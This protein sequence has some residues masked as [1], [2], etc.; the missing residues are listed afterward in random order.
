MTLTFP[1]GSHNYEFYGDRWS[2]NANLL[3]QSTI[4]LLYKCV[5]FYTKWVLPPSSGKQT[6]ENYVIECFNPFLETVIESP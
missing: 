3:N 5:P 4:W 6:K 1:N 2:S